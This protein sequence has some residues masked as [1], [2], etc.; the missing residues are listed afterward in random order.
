[1]S[2]MSKGKIQRCSWWER[3]LSMVGEVSMVA[4]FHGYADFAEST[5]LGD[6]LF[7]NHHR[8]NLG[9]GPLV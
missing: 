4:L 8:W 6:N 3:D 7:Y 1:M 5:K 2:K 9:W